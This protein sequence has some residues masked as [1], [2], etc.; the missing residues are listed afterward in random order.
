MAY[1]EPAEH[2]LRG[3]AVVFKRRR[4]A[5]WA[6][7]GSYNGVERSRY[8]LGAFASKC[9]NAKAVDVLEAALKKTRPQLYGERGTQVTEPSAPSG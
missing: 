6:W 3:I 5:C 2:L 9:T 7:D 1:V 4:M 8:R